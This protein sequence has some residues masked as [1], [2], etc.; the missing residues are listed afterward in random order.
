MSC[1][2]S[3][4]TDSGIERGPVTWHRLT[5]ILYSHMWT[6]IWRSCWRRPIE[7][8]T[9]FA[10]WK[11]IIGP[12]CMCAKREWRSW[13]G[14]CA[15]HLDG[16]KGLI[17]FGFWPRLHWLGRKHD[18]GPP[19]RIW[20]NSEK[21]LSF[22]NF[23]SQKQVFQLSGSRTHALTFFWDTCWRKFLHFWIFHGYLCI[24]RNQLSISSKSGWSKSSKTPWKP[25]CCHLLHQQEVPLGE[26][27][28][29][30][31]NELQIQKF[32]L[33]WI[34]NI[35]GFPT[36]YHEL[37]LD[38]GKYL[39][40]RLENARPT[41]LKRD[42]LKCFAEY[43]TASSDFLLVWTNFVCGWNFWVFMM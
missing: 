7:T 31:S 24:L 36:S 25:P 19:L 9:C 34:V 20:A 37:N 3:V 40:F 39:K 15:R 13:R 16:R 27:G 42:P 28:F 30:G 10:T 41:R 33:G 38:A 11:A 6:S 18:G 17:H 12:A 26:W 43:S 4:R 21:I 29:G 14:G 22:S 32:H 23:W 2:E 35:Q 1:V 5:E 8:K